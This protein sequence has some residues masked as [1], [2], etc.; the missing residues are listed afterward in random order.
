MVTIVTFWSPIVAFTIFALV[1]IVFGL[2][3]GTR[4]AEMDP[5]EAL[6]HE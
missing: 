3:P 2:Y 4:A 5:V 6:R 1:G